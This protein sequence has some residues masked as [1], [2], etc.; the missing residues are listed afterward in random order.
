VGLL[1][2]GTIIIASFPWLILSS[3]GWPRVRRRFY[4]ITNRANKGRGIAIGPT[5]TRESGVAKIE[6]YR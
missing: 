5:K 6:L 1:E 3:A 2:I 4:G